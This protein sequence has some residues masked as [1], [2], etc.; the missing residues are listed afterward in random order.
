M[1]VTIEPTEQHDEY[2][3]STVTIS[4]PSDDVSC[5]DAVSMVLNAL[6]AWGYSADTV[7]E[8]QRKIQELEPEIKKWSGNRT[9]TKG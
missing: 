6:V 5:E 2:P 4:Y 8:E 7:F 9:P 3:N 1:K